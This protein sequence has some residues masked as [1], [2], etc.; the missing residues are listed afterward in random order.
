MILFACIAITCI[1]KKRA[2]V[3]EMKTILN[4][5]ETI[6]GID[7]KMR[8]AS[9]IRMPLW[10]LEHIKKLCKEEERTQN[11]YI[12]QAIDEW[13]DKRGIILESE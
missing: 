6:S 12:Q 9:G 10:Q 5:K 1:Q 3:T 8:V 2:I 13:F 11:Y 4:G 7:P